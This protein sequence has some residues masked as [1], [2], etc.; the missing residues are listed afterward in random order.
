[1][2][3]EN[4][5]LAKRWNETHF[6]PLVPGR[7]IIFSANKRT[8]DHVHLSGV[9]SQGIAQPFGTPRLN[10]YWT[11]IALGQKHKFKSWLEKHNPLVYQDARYAY[12]PFDKFRESVYRDTA[13]GA[14]PAPESS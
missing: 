5:E 6:T 9:N 3:V 13:L 1:M 7:V 2:K 8:E 4:K 14:E 11:F 12:E 10:G